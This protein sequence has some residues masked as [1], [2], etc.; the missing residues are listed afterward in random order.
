M[1]LSAHPNHKNPIVMSKA[2]KNILTLRLIIA[3]AFIVLLGAVLN[4]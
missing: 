3:A 2:E 1:V 4:A